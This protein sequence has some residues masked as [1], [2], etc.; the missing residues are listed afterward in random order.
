MTDTELLH[1]ITAPT[2]YRIITLLLEYHYCVKAV[3][4]K[5]GIS[6]SAVSQQIQVLK[7]CGLVTGVRLDYQMHYT[8]NRE[9]L[10]KAVHAVNFLISAA[11]E[12]EPDFENCDCG[13]A[14]TCKRRGAVKKF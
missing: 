2:R 9:L 3:A 12:K 4:S 7:N 10:K 1:L 13:F 5:L 14:A 6:E 8:V 11:G